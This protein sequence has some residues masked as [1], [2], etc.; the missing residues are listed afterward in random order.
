MSSPSLKHYSGGKGLAHQN[1]WNKNSDGFSLVEIAVVAAVVGFLTTAIIVNFSRTRTN[2]DESVN[3]LASQVRIA[4]TEAVSSARYNNYNPCGYGIHYIDGATFARYVGPN[5]STANCQ[6][7]NRNY[8]AGED[9]LLQPQKFQDS[10]IE[11]KSSFNDIYFEPPD[12]KT[13]LNDSSALNQAPIAITVGRVGTNC[14][15]NCK[16]IYVY[17]SGKIDVQ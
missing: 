13:Y 1:F 12:P 8:S 7:I 11:F 17:P 6:A 10:R 14:P 3:F 2:L 16:T 9:A 5:A 4:Q 15:T